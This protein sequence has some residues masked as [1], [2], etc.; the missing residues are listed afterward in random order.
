MVTLSELES[1]ALQL[2]QDQRASLAATLLESLP[3]VF[4]DN[5]A[6]LQEAIR[7]DAEL[8][9]DSSAGMSLEELRQALGR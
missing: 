9:K 2:P 7:R 8:D 1:Q 5:D 4:H 6:G 3:A